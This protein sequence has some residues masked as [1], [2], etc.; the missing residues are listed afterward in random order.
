MGCRVPQGGTLLAAASSYEENHHGSGSSGGSRGITHGI[1]VRISLGLATL[2]VRA[3]G[4][5][6]SVDGKP[7]GLDLLDG[8]YTT[9]KR[10]RPEPYPKFFDENVQ[11]CRPP[12]PLSGGQE[13]RGPS[14]ALLPRERAAEGRRHQDECRVE[15]LALN[16]RHTARGEVACLQAGADARARLR[17]PMRCLVSGA[18]ASRVGEQWLWQPVSSCPSEGRAV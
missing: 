5:H 11:R 14:P 13:C 2:R 7:K 15:P 9:L 10:P 3:L 4:S 18:E 8:I 6:P 1:S 17:T 12:P 16:L